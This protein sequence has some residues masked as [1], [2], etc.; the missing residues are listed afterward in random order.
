M[1]HVKPLSLIYFA[2]F[3]ICFLLH[4]EEDFCLAI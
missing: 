3:N 2:I 1:D 4:F